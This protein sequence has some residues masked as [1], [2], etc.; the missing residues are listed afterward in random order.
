MIPK[1]DIV[2]IFKRQAALETRSHL[3]HVVLEALQGIQL[4]RMD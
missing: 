4:T 1:L 3:P 2:E